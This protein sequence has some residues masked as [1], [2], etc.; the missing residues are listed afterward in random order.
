V[1]LRYIDCR[2]NNRPDVVVTTKAGFLPQ[3]VRSSLE[4]G[5]LAALASVSFSGAL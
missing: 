1:V 3:S 2:Q 5:Q 4:T